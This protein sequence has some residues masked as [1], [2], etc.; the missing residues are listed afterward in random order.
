MQ[1]INALFVL[2]GHLNI[3]YLVGFLYIAWPFTNFK[4]ML[5][6]VGIANMTANL[7]N[8]EGFVMDL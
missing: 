4:F 2:T 3:K 1:K 7:T 6:D 8:V 5:G